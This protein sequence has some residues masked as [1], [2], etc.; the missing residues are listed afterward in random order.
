V[1]IVEGWLPKQSDYPRNSVLIPLLLYLYIY[2]F[3]SQ[4]FHRVGFRS[5]LLPAVQQDVLRNG[6]LVARTSALRAVAGQV[7]VKSLQL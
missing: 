4:S 7:T 3:I 2:V 6:E 1:L 5:R